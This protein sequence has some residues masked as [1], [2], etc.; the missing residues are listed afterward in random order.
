MPGVARHFWEGM[1]PNHY[2]G[3]LLT[4]FRRIKPTWDAVQWNESTG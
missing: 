1:Q 4:D 3:R 2:D